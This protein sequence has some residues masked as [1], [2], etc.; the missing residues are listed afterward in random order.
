VSMSGGQYGHIRVRHGTVNYLA[1]NNSINTNNK[2]NI[3]IDGI[4][5][6]KYELTPIL[7][8]VNNSKEIFVVGLFFGKGIPKDMEGI[9]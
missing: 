7:G 4:P 9:L 6:L 8:N 1:K 2:L 5:M 3:G